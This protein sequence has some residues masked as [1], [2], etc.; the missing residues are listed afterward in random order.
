[1]NIAVTDASREHLQQHLTAGRGRRRPLPALQGCAAFA[2]V[3]TDHGHYSGGV[4]WFLT[5]AVP[6]LLQCEGR[7]RG[8]FCAV[9][10]IKSA[11]RGERGKV[12]SRCIHPV[13][14]ARKADDTTAAV[15]YCGLS[16]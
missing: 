7:N 16:C 14:G 3:K 5:H 12:L 1:V 2:Y 9:N 6:R 10:E 15:G 13:A 8:F 11:I 4:W